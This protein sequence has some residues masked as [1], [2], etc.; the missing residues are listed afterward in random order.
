MWCCLAEV[1]TQTESLGQC[2]YFCVSVSAFGLSEQAA[3][4]ANQGLDEG[5][6]GAHLAV[7]TLHLQQLPL[8]SLSETCGHVAL[9]LHSHTHTHTEDQGSGIM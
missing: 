8:Q 3:D 1:L 9:Q 4:P 6:A 5:V 2:L 7:Q